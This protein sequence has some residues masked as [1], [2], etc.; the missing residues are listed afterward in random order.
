MWRVNEANKYTLFGIL[1]GFCFPVGSILFLYSIGQLSDSHSLVEIVREAHRNNV[2]LYVIDSAPLFLGLFARLAGIRQDRILYFSESLEAQVREKTESLRVALDEAH[3]ANRTIVHMAEHD[4]L[5]GLLNR[6]SF[7]KTLDGW[8]KYAARCKRTGTLLFIDLDDFKRINDIHGH[9]AG[10]Q[11]LIACAGLLTSTLRSTDPIARWGGDE[12]AALLPETV[13]RDAHRVATKLIST[14]SKANFTV[15]NQSFEVSASIGLAFVPD[16][17]GSYLEV[18]NC[19]DA[20]MYEAKKAGKNCWRVYMAAE[21]G[22]QPLHDALQW[23]ERIRRAL[24]NDQFLLLYQPHFNLK[25]NCTEGYEA[26]LRMEDRTGQL[27]LP[28][29]FLASAER[30]HLTS[31][32]D[33]MGA[34]KAAKKM[35]LLSSHD[36]DVWLSVN[37]SAHTLRDTNLLT[38]VAAAL[39]EIPGEVNKLRF[40]ISESSVLQDPSLAREVCAQ[41]NRLGCDVILDDFGHGSVSFDLFNDLTLSMVKLHPSLIRGF[42]DD[43]GRH[44]HVKNLVA[45]LHKLNLKVAAKSVED[46]RLLAILRDIE[47]DYAQGFAV[48]KPLESIEQTT[49][50]FIA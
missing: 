29:E 6:R 25:K 42:L 28:G 31:A 13:G 5:T 49:N 12:F 11:Y 26:L 38:H 24:N 43:S 17:G 39:A 40:E 8:I 22:A 47:M 18:L 50:Y 4:S 2:L 3:R 32:I 48:G 7:Q 36:P 45:Q 41:L 37:L 20:A 21:A 23:A 16:H 14:F 19:A 35:V 1:F 15:N 34:R 44:Q 46:E 9:G 30:Y 27:I 33:F 10:D